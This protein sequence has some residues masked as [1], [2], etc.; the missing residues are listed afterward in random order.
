MSDTPRGDE[1]TVR[2]PMVELREGRLNM[3][4]PRLSM[5]RRLKMLLL[6]DLAL[7][8]VTA[9]ATGLIA[10]LLPA[11]NWGECITT[12]LIG[13]CL[14]AISIVQTISD[15][16]N[17]YYTTQRFLDQVG[18]WQSDDI[19]LICNSLLSAGV[20]VVEQE[21]EKRTKGVESNGEPLQKTKTE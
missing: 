9:G 5:S 14:V 16:R 11:Q 3:T 13:G 12:T 8:A 15:F 21:V 2:Q 18:K 4:L 1:N 19:V 7:I 20:K 10:S 6:F 17:W